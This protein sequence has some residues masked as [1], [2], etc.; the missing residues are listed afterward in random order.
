[1]ETGMSKENF[2]ISK[3]NLDTNSVPVTS[4][5]NE[6]VSEGLEIKKSNKEHIIVESN[7]TQMDDEISKIKE[8]VVEQENYISYL[9]SLLIKH[10]KNI[11]DAG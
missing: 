9:K 2:L 5:F 4:L 6:G 1:M 8:K 7:C 3:F 10:Q 11:E